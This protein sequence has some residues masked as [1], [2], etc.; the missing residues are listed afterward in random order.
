MVAAQADR[1]SLVIA[2]LHCVATW[3]CL[4]T[5]HPWL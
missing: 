3:F 2:L 5:V 1:A 4:Q